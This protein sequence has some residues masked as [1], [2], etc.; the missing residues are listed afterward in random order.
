MPF[1]GSG[2]TSTSK[3]HRDDRINKC[4]MI[5]EIIGSMKKKRL[6]LI[7]N[8]FILIGL[9]LSSCSGFPGFS[10][11]VPPTPT[12]LQQTSPPAI[13][14]TDP[15]LNTVIGHLSPITFYF[16]QPMNKASVE[17]SF[18]GLPRGA[19]VW[20]DESTLFYTPAASYAPNSK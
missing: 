9:I 5:W 11:P 19:F 3:P 6:R 4:I 12:F 13:I 18:S 2:V 17:P 16:N 20:K 8:W 10:T 15:P 14:E 7:L 1:R